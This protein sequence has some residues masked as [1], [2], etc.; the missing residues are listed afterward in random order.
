MNRNTV[1]QATALS[2]RELTCFR[3]LDAFMTMHHKNS[4]LTFQQLTLVTIWEGKFPTEEMK[5]STKFSQSSTG[6]GY[7]CGSVE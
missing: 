1:E 6:L 4:H 2:H 7:L 3:A 5:N